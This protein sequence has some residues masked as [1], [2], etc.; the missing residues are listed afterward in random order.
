MEELHILLIAA[1]PGAWEPP[2]DE[3]EAHDSQS[4]EDADG[5][6][7]AYGAHDCVGGR[8]RGMESVGKRRPKKG[9]ET[10]NLLEGLKSQAAAL[11]CDV[12]ACCEGL[13][14]GK[15][16]QLA[17]RS[18][19]LLQECNGSVSLLWGRTGPRGFVGVCCAFARCRTF[20]GWDAIGGNVSSLGCGVQA[21]IFGVC[22]VG[23]RAGVS[24]A[25]F[26]WSCL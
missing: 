24:E 22:Q 14:L 25:C 21:T 10:E 26:V 19:C 17:S 9:I 12:L 23:A 1:V 11:V 8:E 7:P 16:H 18:G 20:A 15:R 13:R 2:P 4:R 5:D 3:N 6:G